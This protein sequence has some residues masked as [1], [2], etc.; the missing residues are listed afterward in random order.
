LNSTP[1]ALPPGDAADAAAAA[2][3]TETDGASTVAASRA[4][5]SQLRLVED[6]TKKR[7]LYVMNLTEEVVTRPEDVLAIMKRANKARSHSSHTG[8]RTFAFAL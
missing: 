4:K 5:Q 6:P 2:A 3:G 8:L 1:T 7:G